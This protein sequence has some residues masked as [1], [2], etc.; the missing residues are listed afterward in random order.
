MI[1]FIT[2]MNLRSREI[3]YTPNNTIKSEC[4]NVSNIRHNLIFY[5]TLLLLVCFLFF[6]TV[7]IYSFLFFL[8]KIYVPI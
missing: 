2:S 7:S 4:S 3:I 1:Y 5:M 6:L 8:S